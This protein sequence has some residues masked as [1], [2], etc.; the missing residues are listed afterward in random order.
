MAGLHF[1]VIIESH[2]V[3]SVF[4]LQREREVLGLFER[5]VKFQMIY[6]FLIVRSSLSMHNRAPGRLFRRNVY[7]I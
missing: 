6:D 1:D 4:L 3:D 5:I 2:N 7:T